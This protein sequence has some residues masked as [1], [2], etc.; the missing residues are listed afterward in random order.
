[1]TLDFQG[2][3]ILPD[4]K[5]QNFHPAFLKFLGLFSVSIPSE[6]RISLCFSLGADG[7]LFGHLSVG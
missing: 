2:R 3:L 1:M 7:F 6:K 4:K 5:K